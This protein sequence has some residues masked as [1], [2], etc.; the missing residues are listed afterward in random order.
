MQNGHGRSLTGWALAA[1]IAVTSVPWAQSPGD[2]SRFRGPN[3]S[4]VSTAR[5]VPTE[6]GPTKNLI[7]KLDLPPGH[8]SPILQ[9]DRL[10]L[11][12]LR[13]GRLVTIAVDRTTGKLLWERSR[14][15]LS[16]SFFPTTG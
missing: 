7:W 16:T 15:T 11:T 1:T 6:F 13:A 4:G 8:S 5:N 2:W 9:S 10:Y 14:R 12:G 3:G